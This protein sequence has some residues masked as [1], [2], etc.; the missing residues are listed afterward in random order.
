MSY[1]L[2]RWV[3]LY[4]DWPPDSH[5]DL[6]LQDGGRL[7]TWRLPEVPRSGVELTA[8]RIADHRLIYLDYQGP[9]S[10][11]RGSVRRLDRGAYERLLWKDHEIVVAVRGKVLQGTLALRAP[12]LITEPGLSDALWTLKYEAPGESNPPGA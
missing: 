8:E 3:L 11:N 9:I 7:L 6:M 4:H 12:D 2:P 1:D 10:G 5:Y